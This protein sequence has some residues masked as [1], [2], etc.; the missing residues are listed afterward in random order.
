MIPIIRNCGIAGVSFREPHAKQIV[1]GLRDG[2]QLAIALE[3]SNPHDPYAVKV[4]TPEGVHLGYIPRESAA[5][6]HAVA[7]LSPVPL[8]FVASCTGTSKAGTPQIT[9]SYRLGSD[10]G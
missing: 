4:L 9:V 1:A 6:I 8:S 3:A 5:A 7:A 2:H 10:H